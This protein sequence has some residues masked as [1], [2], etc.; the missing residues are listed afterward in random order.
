MRN[1]PNWPYRS[2]AVVVCS[3]ALLAGCGKKEQATAQRGQVVA[4]VGNEVITNQELENEFRLANIPPDKQKDPEIVKQV[5]GQ[6]VTRKYLLEQALN[7]KLDREP[8]VLLDLLRAREQVLEN[9]YLV[10]TVMSK[11]PTKADIDRYIA[12]NPAKFSNRKLLQ[13][14]QIA[15][16]FGPASQSVVESSRDAKSLDEI[17]QQLT[18]ASV[19]HGRQGGVLSSGDVGPELF[20]KIEAK[21]AD[22]VFFIRSGQNGIFFKVLGEE[23]RPLEGAAAANVAR[24]LMR[25]DALKGE[26]GIATYSA[27][28]EAKFEGDYQQIMQG[29][30]KS[31]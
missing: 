26:I 6:L 24:Q 2:V 3:A 4:H 27:N 12:D 31:Q 8:G 22:D 17:D 9:A 25:N 30:G 19:P 13:V 5:L 20:D 23:P 21:K 14:D 11:P 16:Q 18:A 1:W 29:Q 28:M 15:F 10:R 7:A